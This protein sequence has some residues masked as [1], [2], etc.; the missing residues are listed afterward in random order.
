MLLLAGGREQWLFMSVLGLCVGAVLIISK[1]YMNGCTKFNS[2]NRWWG[3]GSY[4]VLFRIL[5]EGK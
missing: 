1:C 3:S 4:L 2:H 5:G